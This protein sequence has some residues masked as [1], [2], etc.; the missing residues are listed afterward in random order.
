MLQLVFAENVSWLSDKDECATGSGK[1]LPPPVEA[2][3]TLSSSCRWM[4]FP[5][6]PENNF[7]V[8]R[9]KRDSNHAALVF[10]QQNTSTKQNVRCHAAGAVGAVGE[11]YL[12]NIQKNQLNQTSPVTSSYGVRLVLC[13]CY[14]Y[15]FRSQL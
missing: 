8:A 5:F 12:W 2:M 11:P 14:I 3:D 7:A 1:T 15:I 10:K 4:Q 6:K 13:R 9:G